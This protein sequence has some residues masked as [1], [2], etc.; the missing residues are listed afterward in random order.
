VKTAIEY[1]GL[2]EAAL[3]RAEKWDPVWFCGDD[4]AVQISNPHRTSALAEAQVYATLAQASAYQ[5]QV[6]CQKAAAAR[7]IEVYET[8][9]N[10]VK[11]LAEANAEIERLNEALIKAALI[12]V[13]KGAKARLATAAP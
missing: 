7:L 11:Q 10:A 4:D 5:E 2:A 3:D 12:G 9:A 1:A 13:E 8:D 6:E